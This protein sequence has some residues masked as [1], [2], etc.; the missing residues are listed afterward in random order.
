MQGKDSLHEGWDFSAHVMGGNYGSLK[1]GEYVQ[2]VDD[3]V[4]KLVDD[5]NALGENG[6]GVKQL[7]G[8]V[9]EYWHADTFNI[10]A[11]LR[12]SSNRAFVEGSTENA[13]VDVSTNYGKKYSLK[14][15][16]TA[17][18]SVDA[19]AKN[20]IKAYHEYLRKPRKG[21]AISF[22]EYLEKY[23]YSKDENIKKLIADYRKAVENGDKSTLEQY[24]MVHAGEYDIA[25]LLTSVYNGQ[26]RLIPTDQIK[27][28]IEYLNREIAKESTKETSNRAAVL[29]NYKETLE[30]LVDRISDGTGTESRTLT[31]EEAEVIASLVKEGKFKTEDF[32]LTLNDLIRTDY[33]LQQALKA[34]YTAATITLVLQLAPEIVKA[35]DYLIKNGQLDLNQVKKIGIKAI[36]APA[37][38][39]LRGSISSALT[40]ACKIGKLGA[41]LVDVSPQL[42]GALT[43]ITLDT[44]KNSFLVATGKMA[45]QEMGAILTKEIIISGM[46]LAGGTIAQSLAPEMPVLAYMLGSFVGSTIASVSLA[47]GEKTLLSFCVETGFTC[48]GL[49]K[50]D[51]SLPE[52]VLED[53]GLEIAK[54]ERIYADTLDVDRIEPD[55]I[56]VDRCEYDTIEIT[57]LK[58]GII[59][60]NKIGYVL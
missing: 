48:F 21:N 43:V 7:K 51:Y 4:K 45:P 5:M 39:F 37:E 23:G 15:I 42:I 50:Q 59:G 26:D 30:K 29:A 22:E 9:A 6:L 57:I 3:A 44:V 8:F 19:Q 12:D 36:T 49:V 20:V 35:I 17:E 14:Y 34:G 25:S 52:E 46:G 24:M 54:V 32:G 11:A 56:E 40:I 27:E 1:A 38:G 53:M 18:A 28:A 41:S 13:S 31:K 58:R 60:V 16:R 33:I 47:V 2:R 10:E 55:I